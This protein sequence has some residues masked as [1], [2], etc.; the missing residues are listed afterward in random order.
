MADEFAAKTSALSNIKKM[1]KDG[2]AKRLGGLAGVRVGAPDSAAPVPDSLPG[3]PKTPSLEVHIIK[4]GGAEGSPGEE[5]S[6]SPAE[7]AAEGDENP[8]HAAVM[9]QMDTLLRPRKK[10]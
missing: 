8:V 3:A 9:K 6:E 4:A 2:Q 7:A 10:A 1:L 5:A